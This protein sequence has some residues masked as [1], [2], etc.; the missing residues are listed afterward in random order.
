MILSV[1]QDRS[2]QSFQSSV[3]S[4]RTTEQ[5]YQ[6]Q[7]I[8]GALSGRPRGAVA[9]WLQS[10][11]YHRIKTKLGTEL[12]WETISWHP[13]TKL[14]KRPKSVILV[15][16]HT[17]FTH[18]HALLAVKSLWLC[19]KSKYDFYLLWIKRSHRCKS[20]STSKFQ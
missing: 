16:S 1:Q 5:D 15:T 7:G 17:L 10:S 3:L 20:E 18:L 12:S 4:F 11:T 19:S 9:A 2:P 13:G 6:R 8:P 14:R